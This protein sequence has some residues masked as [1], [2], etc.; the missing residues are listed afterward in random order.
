MGIV[1]VNTGYVFHVKP[2]QRWYFQGSKC[3]YSLAPRHANLGIS[4]SVPSESSSEMN[5]PQPHPRPG[6]HRRGNETPR[7]P[8]YMYESERPWS[9]AG[10]GKLSEVWHTGGHISQLQGQRLGFCLAAAPRSLVPTWEVFHCWV[11]CLVFGFT[12]LSS[13][14]YSPSAQPYYPQLRRVHLYTLNGSTCS[15]SSCKLKLNKKIKKL[16]KT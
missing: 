3:L 9:R 14:S 7:F 6:G 2:L 8:E 13:T 15:G 4:T 12:N 16:K 10:C 5:T 11:L 1:H